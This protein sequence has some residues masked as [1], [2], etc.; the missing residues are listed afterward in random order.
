MTQEEDAVADTND[1]ETTDVPEITDVPEPTEDPVAEAAPAEDD[2]LDDFDLDDSP[3]SPKAVRIAQI[4]LVVLALIIVAV[5][6]LANRGSDDDD[7]KKGSG[8]KTDQSSDSSDGGNEKSTKKV[9]P[10]ELGG[11]PAGLGKTK[12][13]APDVTVEAD[14]GAYLW[15]DFDGWHLWVVNG[16]GVPAISGSISSNDDLD[17]AV[18]AIDGAGSVTPNGKTATFELPTDV[19]LAGI[20][21]NPGFYSDDIVVT[22]NG[23]DGAPIDAALVKTGKKSTQAPFPIVIRKG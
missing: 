12:Q 17:K 6:V 11:R 2:G 21:F 18:L 7:A 8:D 5:V 3:A 13:P 14:P 16:A 4:G 22:L 20:D 23:P 1:P 19:P 10:P 15:N 9:W